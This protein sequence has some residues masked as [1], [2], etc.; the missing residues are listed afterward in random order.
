MWLLVG[1]FGDEILAHQDAS[2]PGILT[3]HGVFELDAGLDGA[4]SV[5]G[6]GGVDRIHLPRASSG[7]M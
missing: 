6:R 7:I 4:S 2:L 1:I 5:P 3:F